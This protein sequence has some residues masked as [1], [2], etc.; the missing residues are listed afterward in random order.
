M[1]FKIDQSF[2]DHDGV[3]HHVVNRF[4]D[5]NNSIVVSKYWKRGRGWRYEAYTEKALQIG[6]KH[7]TILEKKPTS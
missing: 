1:E 7:R 2:Y 5:G 6:L 3:K 4:N